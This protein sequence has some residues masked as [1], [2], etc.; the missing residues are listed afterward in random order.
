MRVW[1]RSLYGKLCATLAFLLTLLGATQLQVLSSFVEDYALERDQ[2]I[3]WSLASELAERF[4]PLVAE[5]ID[6]EALERAFYDIVIV[7]PRVDVYLVS[8]T[9]EILAQIGV[10]SGLRRSRIDPEPL[11]RFL[12]MTTPSGL[13]LFGDNPESIDERG[14]FS[15]A[16]LE[17]GKVPGFVYVVLN[18]AE[19]RPLSSLIRSSY[20]LNNAL[21]LLF[22]SFL[23]VGLVGMLAFFGITRRIDSMVQIVQRFTGGAMNERVA[24]RSDDEIAVLGQAFNSMA[25][26]ITDNV[27]QLEHIDAQ[28]REFVAIVAHDLRA[29]LT[30]IYGYLDSLVNKTIPIDSAMGA[31]AIETAYRNSKNLIKM[32]KELF[33]LARL[34]AKDFQPETAAIDTAEFLRFLVQKHQPMAEQKKIILALDLKADERETV[35]ADP[36]LIERVLSNLIDNAIKYTPEGGTVTVS[37]EAQPEAVGFAVSDTGEGI[38][39]QDMVRLFER[40]FRTNSPLSQ[41][42]GGTGLGLS[43]VK[44]ILEAHHREIAVSSVAGGGTTFAFSLPITPR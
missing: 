5:T 21:L 39:E 10:R 25:E 40:F 7:N 28:R 11:V 32:V 29:P 14:I 31:E 8:N 36:L 18:S 35:S 24:D 26:R 37:T 20:I 38:S 17:I 42:A 19:Q 12:R 44:R 3:Y 15:A 30:S 23:L 2:T 1:P 6:Y 16:P 34:E 41:Q 4:Q 22:L 33:E 9:G 13:P 43:I 27:R